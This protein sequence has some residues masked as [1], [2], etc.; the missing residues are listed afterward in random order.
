MPCQRIQIKL[1]E[2]SSFATPILR[3]SEQQC[4]LLLFQGA[5]NKR[6]QILPFPTRPQTLSL[7]GFRITVNKRILGQIHRKNKDRFPLLPSPIHSPQSKRYIML[8]WHKRYDLQIE[9]DHRATVQSPAHSS[10][11]Y[12]AVE[13]WLISTEDT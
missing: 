2:I 7:C 9:Y 11:L 13:S 10:S 3:Y 6:F 5:Y 8:T 12:L 1:C 4:D